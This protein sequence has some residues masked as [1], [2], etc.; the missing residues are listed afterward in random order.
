MYYE[1]DITTDKTLKEIFP[2]FRGSSLFILYIWLY[3][4]NI[5]GW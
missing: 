2:I 3:Y 1:M 5:Y 4:W